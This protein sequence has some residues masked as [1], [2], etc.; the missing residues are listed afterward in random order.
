MR[1]EME[2]EKRVLWTYLDV[3]A[4]FTYVILLHR[5]KILTHLFRSHATPCLITRALPLTRKAQEGA[6][7]VKRFSRMQT[8]DAA[9]LLTTR[10][11]GEATIGMRFP[12]LFPVFWKPTHSALSINSIPFH[13]VLIVLFWVE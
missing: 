9:P 8:R 12:Q 7:G 11:S 2:S 10:L 13:R 5:W 4:S 1:Q 6:F 3:R